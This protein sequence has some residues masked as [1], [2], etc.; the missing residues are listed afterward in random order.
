MFCNRFRLCTV[1]RACSHA[2]NP[3][4]NSSGLLFF[5]FI[6]GG[7]TTLRSGLLFLFIIFGAPPLRVVGF[8][9]IIWPLHIVAF[10][11]IWP[12]SYYLATFYF[13]LF[14]LGAC[15]EAY[16][17]RFIFWASWAGGLVGGF[18]DQRTI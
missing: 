13:I 18:S 5:F 11:I 7:P 8:F 10:F 14:F 1:H 3:V 12:H 15:P 6:F 9:I 2:I 16:C 4:V 17:R